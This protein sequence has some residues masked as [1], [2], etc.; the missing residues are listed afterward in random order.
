MKP[1]KLDNEVPIR[2]LVHTTVGDFWTWAYSDIL[3]NANRGVFAEFLVAR[4]LG[5]TDTPRIEW[6]AVDLRYLDKKIEIKAS[7][8]C[9]TWPQETPSRISFDIAKKQPWDAAS[10]T[11]GDE[12]IRSSDC[13]VFYLFAEK[14]PNSGRFRINARPAGPQRRFAENERHRQHDGKCHDQTNEPF[15]RPHTPLGNAR[16]SAA[17]QRV[18]PVCPGR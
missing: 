1:K 3:S 14:D 11:S 4:A 17:D 12:A 9:Q 18:R 15:R 5:I 2:G 16:P 8:Y 10:N 6:D 7:A 13:Y